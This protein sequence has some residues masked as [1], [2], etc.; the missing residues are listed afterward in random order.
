VREVAGRELKA[1]ARARIEK[2]VVWPTEDNASPDF[3]VLHALRPGMATI[4]GAALACTS[5]PYAQRG[6]LHDPY[7]R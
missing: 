2:V 3:E 1:Q 6:A 5:S 7:K 4:P